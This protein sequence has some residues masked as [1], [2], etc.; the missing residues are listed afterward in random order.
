MWFAEHVMADV[1]DGETLKGMLG[2]K[3]DVDVIVSC[4]TRP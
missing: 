3:G 2:W 1:P 4:D